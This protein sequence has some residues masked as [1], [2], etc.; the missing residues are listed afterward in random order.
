MNNNTLHLEKYGDPSIVLMGSVNELTN[1]GSYGN[2]CDGP[3]CN[4]LGW[5]RSSEA[6]KGMKITDIPV[7][8]EHDP[9][10]PFTRPEQNSK[11]E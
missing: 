6:E 11:R 7:D 10:Q 2:I 5:R 9:K 8:H 4:G 3:P 1:S